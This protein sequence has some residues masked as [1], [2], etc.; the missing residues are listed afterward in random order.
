[1]ALTLLYLEG[2]NKYLA[3]FSSPQLFQPILAKKNYDI[4]KFH[5]FKKITIFRNILN[6]NAPAIFNAQLHKAVLFGQ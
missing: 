6:I 3:V 5:I 2:Y 1:M 4:Y